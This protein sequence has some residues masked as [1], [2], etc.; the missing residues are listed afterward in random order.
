ME[1]KKLKDWALNRFD[2]DFQIQSLNTNLEMLQKMRYWYGD[3]AH[4]YN[5]D[6]EYYLDVAQ[7]IADK[8]MNISEI[9]HDYL[10]HFRTDRSGLI[11]RSPEERHLHEQ[12]RD[13]YKSLLDYLSDLLQAVETKSRLA[14]SRK[15][16]EKP[17]RQKKEIEVKFEDYFYTYVSPE[18][19]FLYYNDLYDLLQGKVKR[20]DEF[21]QYVAELITNKKMRYFNRDSISKQKFLQII[22]KRKPTG[23]ELNKFSD[24][25]IFYK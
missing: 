18:E 22:L 17:I 8:K 23:T 15:Q 9:Y 20:W 3:M 16:T 25:P 6:K 7:K 4:K 12:L 11:N 21:L 2:K 5:M 10:E 19:R 13:G 14:P 1:D 24:L